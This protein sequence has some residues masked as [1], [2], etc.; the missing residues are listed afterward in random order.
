MSEECW[1]ITLTYNEE[2]IPDDGLLSKSDCQLYLKRLRKEAHPA[3]LRYFLTGEYGERHARPHYHLVLFV[4]GVSGLRRDVVSLA[5]RAWQKYEHALGQWS[6]MGFVE[7]SPLN[8]KRARYCARYTTKKV[9]EGDS[10]EFRL[11]SRR[12]G[13]GLAAVEAIVNAPKELGF[14]FGGYRDM[15]DSGGNVVR[16]AVPT[17]ARIEG[18]R[19][20]LDR[21]MLD[22]I[23]KITNI[24]SDE[25]GRLALGHLVHLVHQRDPF[26]RISDAQKEKCAEVRTRR[27]SRPSGQ[28]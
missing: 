19:W 13:L 21:Y 24:E 8:V 23:R 12:P 6:D 16:L 4:K 26:T 18:R 7:C 11:M 17:V 1:F 3:R 22:R 5:T 28:L 9:A 15:R 27:D 2:F 25:A 14:E 10:G 20:S